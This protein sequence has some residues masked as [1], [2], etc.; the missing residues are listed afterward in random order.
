MV[1]FFLNCILF[2]RL[3]P[4]QPEWRTTQMLWVF[5]A[6][7]GHHSTVGTPASKVFSWE[8]NLLLVYL[9]PPLACPFTGDGEHLSALHPDCLTV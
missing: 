5:L 8:T 4:R 6:P 7:L 9:P 3:Q 1:I 2:F